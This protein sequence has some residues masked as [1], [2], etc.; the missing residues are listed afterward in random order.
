MYDKGLYDEAVRLAKNKKGS[1][2]KSLLKIVKH[3]CSRGL[4]D[5]ALQVANDIPAKT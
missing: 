4:Y 5:K 3:L 2:S 1:K